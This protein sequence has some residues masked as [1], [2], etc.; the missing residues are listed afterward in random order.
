MTPQSASFSSQE[1]LEILTGEHN[2]PE[3]DP[4]TQAKPNTSAKSNLH[5]LVIGINQYL[6]HS[7]LKGAVNDANLFK[8]YLV[9]DLRVP[10]TQINT[11]FDTQASRT[12]IIRGFQRLATNPN[13]NRDDPIVIYYAG[14]G[15]EVQPPPSRRNANGPLVQCLV[16]QDAGSKDLSIPG[17]PP[18]P[19]FTIGSLLNQIANAKGDN[20]TVIFD[21]CHSANISR[22]NLGRGAR[23]IPFLCF[24]PLPEGMDSELVSQNSVVSTRSLRSPQDGPDIQRMQSHVLLAA[25]SS[26]GFAYEDLDTVPH[27]GYFTTALLKVLRSVGPTRLTYKSLIQRL[28][29]LKSSSPQDPVCEGI[30]VDRILFDAKVSG[31]DKSF[32]LLEAKEAGIYLRAGTTHGITPGCVFAIHADLILDSTNPAIG[33]MIVDQVSPFQS[34]LKLP[35]GALDFMIPKPAYGRQVGAGNESA[36]DVYF[37][38]EFKKAIRPD[39]R[40]KLAFSGGENDVILRLV[41]KDLAELIIDA[42]TAGEATFTFARLKPAVENRTSTLRRTVPSNFQSVYKVISAAARFIWHLGRFPQPR[43]FQAAVKMEF[44]KLRESGK[45]EE[46]GS[47]ILEVDGLDLNHKGFAR[48]AVSSKDRYAFRIMNSKSRDLYAYLF[49]FSLGNLE[50][51]AKYLQVVG[52]DQV[53]PSLP[54]RGSLTLGYGSGGV[55]PFQFS[56]EPG[57][58]VEVGIFKLFLSTS[59]IDLS[60][61]EQTAPFSIEPRRLVMGNETK[62]NLGALEIGIWDAITMEL[63]LTRPPEDLSAERETQTHTPTE[64]QR[65]ISEAALS[66]AGLSPEEQYE[67]AQNVRITYGLVIDPGSGPRFSDQPVSVL[68]LPEAQAFS[69]HHT[70]VT[71]EITSS[72]MLDAE[73]AHIGFPSLSNISSLPL[74][75]DFIVSN[76]GS[77][78]WMT[79]RIITA[80]L[81][82]NTSPKD[83]QPSSNLISD[84]EYALSRPKDW[85]KFEA[86][87]DAFNTWGMVIAL[88]GVVGLSSV[89]TGIDNQLDWPRPPSREGLKSGNSHNWRMVKVTRVASILELLDDQLREQVKQLYAG[90]IFR[91]TCVGTRRLFGFDGAM[92]RSRRIAEIEIGFSDVRIESIIVRYSCGIMAGPYGIS[93]RSAQSSR[94]DVAKDEGITDILLWATDERISS[95]QL[96]ESSGRASPIYGATL[97]VAQVPKLLNGN[98]CILVGLSG[99]FDTLGITQL[100]T[101]YI[102]RVE[103]DFVSI[104]GLESGPTVTWYLEEER[105][106]RVRGRYDGKSICELQF[107]TNRRNSSP[108][109]GQAIGDDI[110]DIE[111]PKTIEGEDMVLQCM[112]GT[113]GE[114][115]NSILFV[116]VEPSEMTTLTVVRPSTPKKVD[117]QATIYSLCT[118]AH[119]RVDKIMLFEEYARGASI[120]RPTSAK[121]PLHALIIGINKYKTNTHISAAVSDAFN[122]TQYLTNDLLVPEAQ[123]NLL[124]DEQA[125]RSNI[126]KGFEDLARGDNGIKH[127]EAIV[128]YYAGYGSGVK[129]YPDQ[130]L[131]GSSVRCIIPQDVNIKE[132]IFP[133][134]YFTIEALVHMIAQEKGKNITLIFDCGYSVSDFRDEIPPGMRSINNQSFPLLSEFPVYPI[135]Q[136]DLCGGEVDPSSLGL[137]FS[138]TDTHI[139][140]AACGHGEVAFEN[141][142]GGGCLLY[143]PAT[144]SFVLTLPSPLRAQNPICEGKDT[145]RILFDAKVK[146]SNTSF[147]PIE[148]KQGGFYLQAG[149]VKGI[150]PGFKYAIHTGDMLGPYDTVIGIIEVDEVDPFVAHVKDDSILHPLCYGRQ[151]GYGLDQAIHVHVTEEFVKAAEP[152][153][154][155]LRAFSGREGDIVLRPA[156]PEL[157]QIILSV[158]KHNETTFTLTNQVSVKHGIQT[159]APSGKSS[160]PPSAPHVTPVLSGLAKWNWYL[161]QVPVTRQFRTFIDVEF[162]KLQPTGEHTDEGNPIYASE[163]QNLIVGDGVDMINNTEDLFG[164]RVMNRSSTDL[165][166]YLVS[167]SPTSLAIKFIP[168]SGSS[169]NNTLLPKS[170]CITIGYGTGGEPPLIFPLDEIRD[171]GATI[172]RLFV[173]THPMDFEGVEQESPFGD[174]GVSLDNRAKYLFGKDA[175]WDT[176]DVNVVY[177]SIIPVGEHTRPTPGPIAPA[178]IAQPLT[179]DTIPASLSLHG[180]L[181]TGRSSSPLQV[182]V[183]TSAVASKPWFRTPALTQQLLNS[184]RC[185]RLR[186][187]AS[188]KGPNGESSSAE[189]GGYFEI[190]IIAPDGLPKLSANNKVMTYISH[191]APKSSEWKDGMI[192]GVDHEIWRNLEAG[193]WFAAFVSAKGSGWICEA[194]MGNLIFW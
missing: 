99:G 108:A 128:V 28:P 103:G 131:N 120:V 83:F 145:D 165:Y 191:H 111:A 174:N 17:V 177:S 90:L 175:V 18:I 181:F 118:K 11:L 20:I 36:L 171:V 13:I 164:V 159:L 40:W 184:V 32:I 113:S 76:N 33:T 67:L 192:F 55:E 78:N 158:N 189:T 47:P 26:T 179:E 133:I 80:N 87:K 53:D 121:P 169:S 51:S 86:L 31:A 134:T 3:S 39:P 163:G 41:E 136:G 102:S 156:T 160:I 25:C 194:E 58:S 137:C 15:A 49:Y 82:F 77:Q 43:P 116:W 46:T 154:S 126:I 188:A 106:T 62:H 57:E 19:D 193:D 42:N 91:S 176:L 29:K 105:I 135:V 122:F 75:E 38:P 45:Y 187:L 63:E 147:I 8:S 5:A 34:L 172:L 151:V 141:R 92:N 98:G 74:L 35:D 4:T 107:I 173:S 167:F 153:D 30:N 23:S 1:V 186:T 157:A 142:E 21:S 7:Q 65:G 79:R 110:F 150:T 68:M 94:F 14:H 132:G 166:V 48:V 84:I 22:I 70:S 95:I 56:L 143:K 72:N 182:Q 27:H 52:N 149:L 115:V 85:Q 10:E 54:K 16:P 2:S 155:W 178:V 6:Y 140:L 69:V 119:H 101:S 190:S 88:S 130:V 170:R 112:A 81:S 114:Y 124:L 93:G 125:T 44:Y 100:Q 59:P 71:E 12:E 37:T 129:P 117:P 168:T 162:Y 152:S 24:Y 148:P 66:S 180:A 50:I 89:S 97:N 60:S 138:E 185:M 96:L 73:L 146:G 139:L 183:I 144:H 161:R 61:I 109:F 127:N 104:C 64:G 9:N 123:I